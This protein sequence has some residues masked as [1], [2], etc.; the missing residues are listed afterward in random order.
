MT[1]ATAET[2]SETRTLNH[3]FVLQTKCTEIEYRGLQ[4]TGI[5]D[6]NGNYWFLVYGAATEVHHKQETVCLKVTQ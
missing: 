3:Q 5:Y 1:T 2:H 4:F 6:D